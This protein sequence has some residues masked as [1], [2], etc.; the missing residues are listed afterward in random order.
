MN[1]IGQTAIGPEVVEL[2]TDTKRVARFSVPGGVRIP[3]LSVYLDGEGS[4]S[5]D[6]VARAVVYRASDSALVATSDEVAVAEGQEA[7]WVDFRFTENE[8]GLLVSDS[9]DYDFGVHVGGATNRIRVRQSVAAGSGQENI[10]TYSDG[11]SATFGGSTPLDRDLSEFATYYEP[12]EPPLETDFYYARLP[13]TEAQEKLAET[14]LLPGS[15]RAVCGWHHTAFDPF[16]GSYAIVATGGSLA[17]H[18]GERIRIIERVSGNA[19]SVTAFVHREANLT[20]E[21]SLPR[22][23]FA[24]LGLLSEPSLV[25]DVEVYAGA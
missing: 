14:G 4:G 10:D 6:A 19:R 1:L 3:K 20:E 18:V 5:G 8:A 15:T 25:V 11:A 17:D 22:K 21:I 12:W 13:F 9:A 2:P 7:G 24:E 16:V 23:L